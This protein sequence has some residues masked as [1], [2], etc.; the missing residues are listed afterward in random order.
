[1]WPRYKRTDRT[2]TVKLNG[3]INRKNTPITEEMA[4][5]AARP[6]NQSLSSVPNTKKAEIAALKSSYASFLLHKLKLWKRLT[7]SRTFFLQSRSAH[8]SYLILNTH[9][10]P[11]T[12]V[13]LMTTRWTQ[14]VYAAMLLI[15]PRFYAARAEIESRFH[16]LGWNST[17][18]M[19][20]RF[21]CAVVASIR[22]Q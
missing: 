2:D 4:E 16:R 5:I 13:W 1:M 15:E 3:T 17:Q 20:D 14:T 22:P 21:T 11:S 7:S 6:Y 10:M 12:E 9:A 8:C 19:I 18:W